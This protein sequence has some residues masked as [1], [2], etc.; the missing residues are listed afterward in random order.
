MVGLSYFHYMRAR[1]WYLVLAILGLFLTYGLGA[2]F[3]VLH[4]WNF[5]LF[6]SRSIGNTAAASAIADVTL[7]TFA[8]WIFVYRES[9]RLGMKRWW[10]YVLS[11]FV[12]G[13]VTP[14][15]VYLFVRDEHLK[16]SIGT[17]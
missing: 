9:K 12:F 15:G 11:T 3:V 6:V 1:Y 10:V 13:L 2:A 7:A 5:D 14:L 8:F 17:K 4:G 16:W